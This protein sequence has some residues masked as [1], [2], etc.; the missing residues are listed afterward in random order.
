MNQNKYEDFVIGYGATYKRNVTQRDNEL[1]ADFSGDDNPLH[2]NDELAQKVGYEERISNGFVTESRLAAALVKAFTSKN[3]I[4]VELEKKTKF[5]KPVYMGEEITAK[6]KVIER[7]EAFQALKIEAQC[8]NQKG[9]KVM[10]AFFVV[11]I[12]PR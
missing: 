2:F 7:L 4:V 5:C 6:V 11:Q 10:T 8:L 1:F 12:L 9:E 3:C